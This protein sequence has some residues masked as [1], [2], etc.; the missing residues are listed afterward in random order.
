M[1]HI[2]GI[3]SCAVR[4][5][6]YLGGHSLGGALANLLLAYLAMPSNI[7]DGASDQKPKDKKDRKKSKPYVLS[8]SHLSHLT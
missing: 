2:R 5:D 6:R 1:P 4:E 3:S 8:S 7:S